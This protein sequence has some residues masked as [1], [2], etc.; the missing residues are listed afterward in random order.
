[1]PRL[2][3]IEVIGRRRPEPRPYT[4]GQDVSLIGHGATIFEPI[5]P[6]DFGLESLV[7]I[8]PAFVAPP[9]IQAVEEIVVTAKRGPTAP[10]RMK[11]PA[12]LKFGT[13]R[14]LGLLGLGVSAAAMLEGERK[15]RQAEEDALAR[16]ETEARRQMK[17][18]QETLRTLPQAQPIPEIVVRAKRSLLPQVLPWPIW[19]DPDADPAFSPTVEPRFLPEPAPAP[20]PQ[21]EIQPVAPPT[22][23]QPTRQPATR[24]RIRPG[25]MPLT[26]P[27]ASPLV[28]P[29][30]FPQPI[31]S[32]SP[33]AQPVPFTQPGARPRARAAP[34]PLTRSEPQPLPFADPS[35]VRRPD[36]PPC[37]KP[38]EEEKDEFRTQCYKKLV[39]EA[40]H[41][42][43]DESFNWVEID[44][45]TGREL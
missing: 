1:M 19:P 23:P 42:E 16:A 13:L 22:I 39:K 2:E 8:T 10:R 25:T 14:L 20:E 18:A 41:S 33:A 6:G 37:P 36:C 5:D 31:P 28:Q 7:P 29:M 21:I 11:L 3:E 40:F 30:P 4:L 32:P 38:S 35:Q 15:R 27:G 26:R 34:R 24:P 45:Y 44:C 43:F 9:A 12:R 17:L